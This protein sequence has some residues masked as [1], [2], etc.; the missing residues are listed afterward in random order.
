MSV[1]FGGHQPAVPQPAPSGEPA[2][3]P[4]LGFILSL[5]AAGLAL[6]IYAC[7]F[8][9]DAALVVGA[10]TLALFLGGGLLAAAG[11]LLKATNTLLPATLLATVAFLL[12]LVAIVQSE[13]DT[14]AISIVILL[15][16]LLQLG[17]LWFALLTESGVIK[18]K[19]KAPAYGPPGGWNPGS[20][21]FPQQQFGGHGQ[22]GQPGQPGQFGGHGQPGQPGQFGGQPGQGQ[23]GQQPFGG[24]PGQA[25]NQPGQPPAQH[26]QPPQGGDRPQFGQQPYGQQPYGGAQGQPGN[27]GS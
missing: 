16:G 5:V 23:F 21:S 18:M 2:A 26:G 7:T 22:P 27:F 8:S 14:T 6:V 17:A 13:L 15:A 20:G 12:L 4:N 19:P 24:Q 10:L 1:P 3:G 11:A 9:D 25:P